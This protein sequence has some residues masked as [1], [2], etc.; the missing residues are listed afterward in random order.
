MIPLFNFFLIDIYNLIS[1]ISFV[2]IE[3]YRV[4]LPKL[5]IMWLSLNQ[6]IPISLF[7][8][9]ILIRFPIFLAKLERV[10]SL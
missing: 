7:D 5:T 9:G 4:K 1:M 10:L 8:S 3:D 6:F 2:F